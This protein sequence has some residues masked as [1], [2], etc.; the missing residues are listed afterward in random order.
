MRSGHDPPTVKGQ[1]DK[2]VEEEC[3]ER[4]DRI[5]PCFRRFVLPD[6]RTNLYFFGP[7]L[8][9]LAYQFASLLGGFSTSSLMI[10]YLS[11]GVL[12]L[13]LVLTGFFATAY[14]I[15]VSLLRGLHAYL[16]PEGGDKE[17]TAGKGKKRLAAGAGGRQRKGKKES[18][19]VWDESG[20][21]ILR[22]DLADAQLETRRYFQEYD[23]SVIYT[24]L[25]LT[26]FAAREILQFSATALQ[27]RHEWAKHLMPDDRI[28]FIVGAFTTYKLFRLL[29]RVGFDPRL[30]KNSERLVSWTV[31]VVGFFVAYILLALVPPSVIDFGI[32]G[33]VA[34][35]AKVAR[36]FMQK[37]GLENMSL[38]FALSPDFVKTFLAVCAGIIS[39]LVFGSCL[40]N[41]KNY[42][43]G[44]DHLLS[45]IAV[46][47]RAPLIGDFL[48]LS[49]LLPPVLSMM[50]FTPMAQRFIIPDTGNKPP[51]SGAT[52]EGLDSQSC[53]QSNGFSILD[54]GSKLKNALSLLGGIWR[55]VVARDYEWVGDF[56]V[57]E[58]TFSQILLW[59]LFLLGC[60]QI[61]L[62][63]VNL[64]SYNN[65]AVLFWYKG[66]HQSKV[67]NPEVIR[68]RIFLNNF[69][70]CR[71]AVQCLVPG[72]LVLHFLGLARSRGSH[73]DEPAQ[74]G[75]FLFAPP[76]VRTLMLFGSWW[77]AFSWGVQT[78]ITFVLFRIGILSSTA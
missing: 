55:G 70:V 47:K 51:T 58:E 63:R 67:Y 75:A 1:I 21:Q 41:M 60:L 59:G 39:A 69:F 56:G 20:A 18:K 52:C 71:V 53:G 17:E 43:V 10:P 24:V 27:A 30:G 72:V 25:G 19:E 13:V 74:L 34:D 66:L 64:Q 49:L 76:L 48:N 23:E 15:S 16:L 38:D 46:L 36:T 57:T 40:R 37:K 68:A 32:D 78:C 12:V 9:I 22:I 4:I 11:V 5:A 31:G 44:T 42:W 7:A 28:T 35:A 65:G 54:L 45:K 8:G 61:C 50:W 3:P 6:L 77:T 26:N 73:L 29:S 2:K 14:R 62:F 33:E